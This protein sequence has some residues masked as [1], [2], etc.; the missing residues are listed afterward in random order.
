[1]VLPDGRAAYLELKSRKGRL[2]PAQQ[3]FRAT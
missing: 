2:S 3:E 1:M